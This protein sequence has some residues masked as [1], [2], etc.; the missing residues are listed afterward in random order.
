MHL[1]DKK[2]AG[3]A[4]GVGTGKILGRIHQV[5][6]EVQGQHIPVAI[7]VMEQESMPFLFGLDN[8]RRFRC[9]IDLEKNIRLYRM[10]ENIDHVTVRRGY[11]DPIDAP[12]APRRQ[13]DDQN[14]R[15][16]CGRVCRLGIHNA[17]ADR[18]A[19]APA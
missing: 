13:G 1:L 18:R 11:L 4:H 17:S 8:M 3:M 9:C 19:P 12:S 5:R 15:W 2:M 16:R 7:T 14:H 10:P 6:I